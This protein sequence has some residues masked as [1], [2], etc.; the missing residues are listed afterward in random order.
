MSHKIVSENLDRCS[1]SR[2]S[3]EAIWDLGTK[4][5]PL[6]LWTFSLQTF[7]ANQNGALY[8][9]GHIRLCGNIGDLVFISWGFRLAVNLVYSHNCQCFFESIVK[10]NPWHFIET[11]VRQIFADWHFCQMKWSFHRWYI[12]SIF[13]ERAEAIHT[14]V[15]RIA[16]VCRKMSKF[17]QKLFPGKKHLWKGNNSLYSTNAC[18]HLNEWCEL[19]LSEWAYF[20]S[21]TYL[22][23]WALNLE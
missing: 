4:V 1:S 2:I 18:S 16:T 8:L 21:K 10:P 19:V 12:S 7:R 5:R 15:V 22:C 3:I 11:P 13:A 20:M 23:Y 17:W 14:T 9:I 6:C